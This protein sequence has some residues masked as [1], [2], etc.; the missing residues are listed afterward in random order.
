MVIPFMKHIILLCDGMAD[1]PLEARD[2]KTPM[3]LADKPTMDGLAPKSEVGLV[4]TVQA[5][6]K[7]GSDVANLSVLGYDPHVYYTGRSPI[8]ALGL[9]ISLKETDM[10]FR[11][12]LVTIS[13]DAVFTDKTMVDHSSDKITTEEANELVDALAAE[14]GSDMMQFYHGVSYRHVF[15]L[16]DPNYT[17]ELTPPHDILGQKITAYLPQGDMAA[18]FCAMMEKSYE[19]LMAH[20]VN[21]ARIARG[22]RPA[23]CLWLWGAGKKPAYESFAEKTGIE[24]ARMITAVPLLKGLAAGMG[25]EYPEIEG[26]TGDYET[27]YAGKAASAIDALQNGYEFVFIHVEAPD[28]CGHDGDA[29][30]KV[31]SLEQIDRHIVGPVFDALK[32]LGEPFKLIITPDHATPCAVRTHTAEMIPFVLYDSQK[33]FGGIEFTEK[34]SLA[35]DYVIENGHTLF[36]TLLEK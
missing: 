31:K 20:P 10:V 26:A 6:M 13:D 32:A 11:L 18:E 7:P 16:N 3:E 17:G 21:K 8:E 15:V 27:N 2:G 1:R 28:E 14:F 29:E 19:I 35:S 12:N 23:N 36:A 33:D 5:G 22:L 34:G 24:K 4:Q 30:L 9:G 25:M